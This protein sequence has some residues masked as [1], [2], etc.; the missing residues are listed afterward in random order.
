VLR[1]L[2][3]V[4]YESARKM[5]LVA[6]Y[7]GEEFALILPGAAAVDASNRAEQ[8]RRNIERSVFHHAETELRVTASL[9]VAELLPDE[10]A[11]AVIERAD[12]ALYVSKDTRRNCVHWHDGTEI[13]PCGTSPPAPK[14]KP[15][16]KEKPGPDEP[17]AEEA[18]TSQPQPTEPTEPTEP[19]QQ[20]QPSQPPQPPQ[21][22]DTGPEPAPKPPVPARSKP[23]PAGVAEQAEFM[24]CL[25]RRIAESRRG[26]G[27]P[28]T[29]LAEI[30]DYEKIVAGREETVGK[31]LTQTV[32]RFVNAAIREMDFP[33]QYDASTFAVLLPR[34]S[35]ADT[36]MVAERLREAISR[37][38]LPDG[39]GQID[40]TVS[41]SAA[42]A[43]AEEDEAALMQRAEQALQAAVKSGGDCCYLHT[44]QWSEPAD[45]L[46]SKVAT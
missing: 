31:M 25:E 22:T 13:Q 6:R 12:A 40:F 21:P 5:D 34:T 32:R 19:P 36:V 26:G 2:G 18:P 27:A 29:I 45:R 20:A 1:G 8:V 33:V 17:V 7:G 10:D 24:M 41:L 46:L 3:G 39:G 35:L 16:P 15:E 37:C 30:D 14:E 4:L 23:L 38:S 44:G 42:V 28:S 43:C 9:G 11:T